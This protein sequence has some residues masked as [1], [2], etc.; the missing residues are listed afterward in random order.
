MNVNSIRKAMGFMSNN[1]IRRK[2]SAIT[3]SLLSL[4]EIND[5]LNKR[6]FFSQNLTSSICLYTTF[7]IWQDSNFCVTYPYVCDIFCDK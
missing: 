1:V 7:I 2:K 3:S 5:F 6:Q 4:A